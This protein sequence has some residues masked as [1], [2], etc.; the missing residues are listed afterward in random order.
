MRFSLLTRRLRFPS[1]FLLLL[2]FTRSFFHGAFAKHGKSLV[3]EKRSYVFVIHNVRVFCQQ[4]FLL[5]IV[6]IFSDAFFIS[7]FFSHGVVSIIHRIVYHC[8]SKLMYSSFFFLLH[9]LFFTLIFPLRLLYTI[10]S[11]CFFII[12]PVKIYKQ[13]TSSPLIRYTRTTEYFSSP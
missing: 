9:S 3:V 13:K 6:K 12:S 4:L 5:G 11:E 2:F 1:V 8:N 10:Y 7:V